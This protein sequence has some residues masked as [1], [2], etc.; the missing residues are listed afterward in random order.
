MG[1]HW[2]RQRPALPL[3]HSERLLAAA[4]LLTQLAA[5]TCALHQRG[6]IKGRVMLD[7]VLETDFFA[8][9]TTRLFLHHPAVLSFDLKAAFPSVSHKFLVP[10]V[11]SV[12]TSSSVHSCFEVYVGKKKLSTIA[13]S[14]VIRINSARPR[15]WI[16]QTDV[17]SFLSPL[18]A[19]FSNSFGP[20]IFCVAY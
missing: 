15:V 2:H 6:G 4:P 14:D 17:N 19:I 13:K 7:N 8:R 1:I 5:H 9:A 3:R 16:I 12:S 11:C 10:Y 20:N 18:P